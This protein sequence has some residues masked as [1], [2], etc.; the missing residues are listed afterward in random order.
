V[1]ERDRQGTGRQAADRHGGTRRQHTLSTPRIAAEP[2][3]L[4]PTINDS[5]KRSRASRLKFDV[6]TQLVGNERQSLAP[7]HARRWSDDGYWQS[8]HLTQELSVHYRNKSSKYVVS[9][10][11]ADELRRQ[12]ALGDHLNREI[13]RWREKQGLPAFTNA[14]LKTNSTRDP[15]ADAVAKINALSASLKSSARGD[16]GDTRQIIAD[17]ISDDRSPFTP[18]D[19]MALRHMSASTLKE[20]RGKY[21]TANS[22]RAVAN[23]DPVIKAMS[24]RGPAGADFHERANERKRLSDLYIARHPVQGRPIFPSKSGVVVNSNDAAVKAMLA[25]TGALSV[26]KKREA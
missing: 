13:D 26:F 21:L 11:E 1:A 5:S 25:Y 2:P 6:H 17:L 10:A 14:H 7:A 19:E 23:A 8:C 3:W 12:C 15:I 24:A 22:H 18:D 9:A 20:M 4:P 16:D